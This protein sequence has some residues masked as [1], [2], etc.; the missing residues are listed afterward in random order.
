[1]KGFQL[2]YTIVEFI[3]SEYGIDSLNKLIRNLAGFQEIF[4]CSETKLHEEWVH[5]LKKSV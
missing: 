4:H 2:S 5:Y 1:M 3:I